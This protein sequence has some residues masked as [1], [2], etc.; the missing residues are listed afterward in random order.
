MAEINEGT[1]FKFMD[2]FPNDIH[3][4]IHHDLDNSLNW[5]LVQNSQTNKYPK[6]VPI[7][8]NHDNKNMIQ[9]NPKFWVNVLGGTIPMIPN[10]KT[11]PIR[12]DEAAIAFCR[13]LLNLF[14]CSF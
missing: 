7:P 14:I 1:F 8:M 9:Y 5:G 4:K 3:K 12:I 11:E 6:N 10:N 2:F 13:F